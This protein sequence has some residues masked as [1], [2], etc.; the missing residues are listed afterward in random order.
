MQ[1]AGEMQINDEATA[2]LNLCQSEI[3]FAKSSPVGLEYI[4]CVLDSPKP[5][6]TDL[7][8]RSQAHRI[9]VDFYFCKGVQI[10]GKHWTKNIMALQCLTSENE[11]SVSSFPP[12]IGIFKLEKPEK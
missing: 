11:G 8:T 5:N 7:L 2:K 1:A 12:G 4:F 10:L 9:T 3:T 6:G